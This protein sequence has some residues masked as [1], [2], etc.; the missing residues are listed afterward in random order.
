MNAGMGRTFYDVVNGKRIEY[1]IER[2]RD[3]SD[4]QITMEGLG[5]DAGFST[6]SAFY[7]HFKAHTGKTPGQFKGEIRPD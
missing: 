7:H 5:Y 6:K 4:G 1:A 3:Q 2:L